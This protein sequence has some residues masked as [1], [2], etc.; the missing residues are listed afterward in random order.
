MYQITSIFY[1]YIDSCER[2]AEEHDGSIMVIEGS[3]NNNKKTVPTMWPIYMKNHAVVH[4][5]PLLSL[6]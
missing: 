6:L 4:F 2:I 1:M 3:P 5:F